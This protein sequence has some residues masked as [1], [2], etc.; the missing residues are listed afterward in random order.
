MKISANTFLLLIIAFLMMDCT[1]GDMVSKK[2]SESLLSILKD[3]EYKT[4]TIDYM[5]TPFV[6]AGD[7]VYVVG[8]QDGSFPDMGWHV[9]G[10]MG[11]IWDHPIKLMDGFVLNLE[12]GEGHLCLSRADEFKNYP[13]AGSHT[14]VRGGLE[15]NRT[16]FVPD[17]MEGI[18]IEYLVKNN[19]SDLNEGTAKF[20]G[21]VDL[22]PVW[23]SERL[24]WEDGEDE[25][26]WDQE[27]QVFMAKDVNNEWYTVLGSNL[28]VIS[29]NTGQSKC[30]IERKGAGTDM[31]I[32]S[33]VVVPPN[34]EVILR[35][36]ISGSY[37][38]QSEALE[39]HTLLSK[40][41]EA[42]LRSKIKR[43]DKITSVASI[44]I[45]D[46]ELQDMYNWV[47]YNTDWLMRDVP[48]QGR[49]LSAGIP[50]YPWWFG[51]DNCYSLQ[52]MFAAGMA[53]DALSTIDLVL[54]LSER[55]NGNGRI[56]HEASTNGVVF[57]PGNL[58]ETPHFIYLLW[59][60]YE[61]TGDRLF[62]ERVYPIAQK[63]IAWMEE[64]DEDKNGYPDGPGMMEIHG[65]H[66]EMIDVVVYQ[67]Q[68]YWAASKMAEELDDDENQM[69]YN[70]KATDLKNKINSD[71]WVEEAASYA[72]FRSTRE[73]AL[74]LI[75]DAII[76]ADTIKKPWT[77]EDLKK[78]K[79]AVAR[80]SASGTR[81][82][83]VHHNWVVNTPL[84]MGIADQDKAL[85]AL[86]TA[87]EYASKYGMY[88][89]GIDRQ[90][91]QDESSKW[92]QFSYVGAVMTLPTG[93][94][95]ISEANY[96]RP[97]KALEYLKMLHN[98]FSYAL[99]GSLYEVSPD[100]GMITQA[101]TIYSVA[102][103]IVNQFF[104][105]KP[106][107]HTKKVVIHPD[108]PSGWNEASLANLPVGD[109]SISIARS[110]N[111]WQID[112][113]ANDW[114]IV[115]KVPDS[116]EKVSVN[117]DIITP[118][119]NGGLFQIELTEMENNVELF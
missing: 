6:T 117:G 68:A 88:V 106:M 46:K 17:Q 58:N 22:M 85:L 67:Q 21:F 89:T 69:V 105:V 37:N 102:Y 18:V 78:L 75:D 100:Y 23:L 83:V 24:N 52:G 9:Q 3:S 27:S 87:R 14:Y 93:V 71:W 111:N 77:V 28:P 26:T 4:S 10:E 116:F 13:V 7:R 114:T 104:G 12:F 115:L 94:Q 66:S 80:Y 101:W 25:T 76:R 20:T 30:S 86:E 38:S 113:I 5:G 65:L 108:M 74:K 96:G 62:L 119:S 2:D 32:T 1:Q 55:E 98:S 35:Y 51:A 60:T 63:G 112:Q 33:N 43:Y 34:E 16:Q 31:S 56:M 72:D 47:K 39:T 118:V 59:K 64:Q 90:E 15:V 44:D 41:P 19:S 84:E 53:E 40:N 61:W 54:E 48:E 91:G 49:G 11:G 110:G 50:D 79:D 81:G 109:N 29:H 107:A 45:P 92:E 95:A 8:N 103:P 99:P 42:L 73:E 36:Y 82:F 57:N 70:E 97:D